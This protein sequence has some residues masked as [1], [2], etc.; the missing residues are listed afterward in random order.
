M[1]ARNRCPSFAKD[2]AAGIGRLNDE[3]EL[4]FLPIEHVRNQR[5]ARA[6]GYRW[7]AQYRLPMDLDRKEI[8]VRLDG[9]AEDT[10][11]KLNRAENLRAIPRSSP[12]FARLYARRGDAESVNR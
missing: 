7:Y 5:F 1:G 8:T 10:K 9:S 11:R 3:G 12:D 6:S 2:G 4:T